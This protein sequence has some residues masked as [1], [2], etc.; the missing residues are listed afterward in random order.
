MEPR[1][2]GAAEFAPVWWLVGAVAA[3]CVCCWLAA[4]ASD[5]RA[6]PA[7]GLLGPL[8][9]VIAG[10]RG[11][12]IRLDRLCDYASTV[13]RRAAAAARSDELTRKCPKCGVKVKASRTVCQNCGGSTE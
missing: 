7:W 13:E 1:G 4:K 11:I 10:L 9:V 12:Q 2:A 6:S 8:G 5:G 3:I